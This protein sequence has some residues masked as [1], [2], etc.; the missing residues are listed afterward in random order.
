MNRVNSLSKY[1]NINTESQRMTTFSQSSATPVAKSSQISNI[2]ECLL[3]NESIRQ[4]HMCPSCCKM[5]C[6]ACIKN[7]IKNKNGECPSCAKPL[8]YGNLLNCS[9]LGRQI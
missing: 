7:W 1:Q 5:F 8:H 4:S 6:E 3:C 9:I 2:I